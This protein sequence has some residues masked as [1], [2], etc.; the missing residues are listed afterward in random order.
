MIRKTKVP[1][2]GLPDNVTWMLENA[3]GQQLSFADRISRD[4]D[5][6]AFVRFIGLFKEYNIYQIFSN[7]IMNAEE[8]WEH[9]AWAK[10]QVASLD[11]LVLMCQ[12]AREEIRRRKEVK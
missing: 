7:K 10:G 6:L 9:R 1:V 4:P 5:F 11:A 8:L 12:Q 3:T 2:K